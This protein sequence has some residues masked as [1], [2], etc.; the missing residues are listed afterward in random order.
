MSST[1]NDDKY[2]APTSSTL[3]CKNCVI[4]TRGFP[5]TEIYKTAN[6]GYGLKV[7]ELVPANTILIEYTGEVISSDECRNRMTG[8]KESDDFYFASLGSGL[9]LDA[10]AMGS[11]ARFANHSCN[12]TCELQKWSVM[13]EP[14][15]V[16]VSKHDMQPDTEITYNYQYFEDG[17]DSTLCGVMKRQLCR[18]RS[19][20]CSGTIGGKTK[21][22]L[23]DTWRIKTDQILSETRRF[24]LDLI[25]DHITA[26]PITSPQR[27]NGIESTNKFHS[28][29]KKGSRT[30]KSI[31]NNDI[32]IDPLSNDNSSELISDLYD[33]LEALRNIVSDTELWL[34]EKNLLFSSSLFPS[35][36][37]SSTSTVAKVVHNTFVDSLTHNN[38]TLVNLVNI[39]HIENLLNKCPKQVKLDEISQLN[40]LI[41]KVAKVNKSID[42]YRGI[43]SNANDLLS[44]MNTNT[45]IEILPIPTPIEFNENMAVVNGAHCLTVDPVTT[46]DSNI[47]TFDVI[48]TTLKDIPNCVVTMNISSN[49]Q[50]ITNEVCG[51]Q[52]INEIDGEVHE[53][54]SNNELLML[55]SNLSWPR[56]TNKTNSPMMKWDD[57]IS[58]C[59]EIQS[60]L[61]VACNNNTIQFLV[62][63]AVQLNNWS[64]K[65]F[66][67]ILYH[68]ATLSLFY[69]NIKKLKSTGENKL[70]SGDFVDVNN[71]ENFTSNSDFISPSKCLE[72]NNCPSNLNPTE[73]TRFKSDAYK[74]FTLLSNITSVYGYDK[75]TIT[76]IFAVEDFLELRLSLFMERKNTL[77][78]NISKCQHDDTVVEN[79]EIVDDNTLHECNSLREEEGTDHKGIPS[80]LNS[81]DSISKSVKSANKSPI[82]TNITANDKTKVS[83]NSTAILH[84]FCCMPEFDGESTVLSQCDGCDRW[85]HPV[86]INAAL[87]SLTAHKSVSQFFCP[88]CRHQNNLHSN[89][90]FSPLT[91]W[92]IPTQTITTIVGKKRNMNSTSCLNNVEELNNNKKRRSNEITSKSS[93]IL[94]GVKS[95]SSKG[96]RISSKIS[97]NLKP[98]EAKKKVI[99]KMNV[100]TSPS[101]SS[102]I[103]ANT[104]IMNASNND[105]LSIVNFVEIVNDLNQVVDESAIK[106]SDDTSSDVVTNNVTAGDNFPIDEK[107]SSVSALSNS[108]KIMPS[109]SNVMSSKNKISEIKSKLIKKPLCV[110]ADPLTEEDVLAAIKEAESLGLS[111]VFNC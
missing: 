17:L 3:Y 26:F 8:M 10:K 94:N 50:V 54:E 91:E 96:S 104:P 15:I 52:L 41:K 85:F 65:Y 29:I 99:I 32:T 58:L 95:N 43:K 24:R 63:S 49:Q 107:V 38:E 111:Q 106:V 105:G 64:F 1:Q 11:P 83:S 70:K 34:S 36:S 86:C 14:R 30:F 100:V 72:S 57:F 22:S 61:P 101:S 48:D 87:T 25:V 40:N 16:L 71:P 45:P 5:S 51:H 66:N 33:K 47:D 35:S 59:K 92:K 89:F 19:D 78:L 76:D 9:F 31:S 74:N 102:S 12:P 7:N 67:N 84:C 56:T 28:Y 77:A 42:S 110:A 62:S 69:P 46:L 13:G 53:R 18:C 6:C 108:S 68:S 20:N 37:S 82:S 2:S 98:K 90:A 60:V 39:Q 81:V 73:L 4:Q 75:S 23:L 21:V 97:E 27:N 44:N 55:P 93:I 88:I 109:K 103:V 80:L 79:I